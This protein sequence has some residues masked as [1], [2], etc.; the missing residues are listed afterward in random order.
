MLDLSLVQLSDQLSSKKE[1]L[2]FL[3]EGGAFRASDADFDELAINISQLP[4]FQNHQAVFLKRGA[5]SGEL[6]AVFLHRT[7]RGPGA[8]GVRRKDY[9]SLGE[10]LSDGLRLALGMG[11]KN[12]LAGLWWGGG[13]GVIGITGV[14][15]DKELIFREYGQFISSLNGCYVTAEDVGTKPEDMATIFSQTRYV[16]CIPPQLGGSGNPSP[17]TAKG[18]F[19]AIEATFRH[20]GLTDWEERRIAIQGLGE[21][22]FRLAELLHERGASL[23]VFDP[24]QSKM[25]K[26]LALD[27]RHQ[28]STQEHI[29]TEEVELLAPCALGAVL[30]PDS[31]PT[32]RCGAVCGAANNQL[33]SSRRDAEA[34]H[35]RGI[36]YI[37]DFVANRMGIVNCADEQYGRLAPDPAIERHMS[38]DWEHAIGPVVLELLRRSK[39]TGKAPLFEAAKRAEELMTK[40]HPIWPG[41]IQTIM[42]QVWADCRQ[43]N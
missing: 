18:V 10:L 4:D 12:S 11:Y 41:R 36:L 16:T 15:Q 3:N 23:L 22:G 32:L 40:P 17:A 27:G 33:A 8:G 20:L 14:C 37:P 35:E 43:K 1:A 9:S 21:V 39:S 26:V 28:A 2:A 24:D 29:L 34:L 31:I 6:F 38:W 5:E 42:T 13:K 19:V 30:N 7:E 25:D